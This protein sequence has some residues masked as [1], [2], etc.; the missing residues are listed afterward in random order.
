MAIILLQPDGVPITAKAERQGSAAL[1]GGGAGRPLGGRSGFRVDTASDVL[2]VTTTAWTVKPC[3]GMI[4]PGAQVDQG[5]YGWANTANITGT[6][7]P[8]DSTLPRK[9]I[10]Y[11]QINDSSSGDGSG[12]INADVKY[13]AGTPN[14][15]PSAPALPVRSFLIGTATVPQVGGGSPTVVLNTARFVAAGGIQPVYSQ[16]ERDGLNK[17]DGL[18]VRRND[19]ST[20]P[21]QVWTASANKWLS[22]NAPSEVYPCIWTGVS[23]WGTGGGLTGTYRVEGDRVFVHARATFGAAATLGNSVLKCPIPP[24]YPIAAGVFHLG[25]GEYVPAA[26]SIRPLTVFADGGQASVWV[27]SDP[28]RTPGDVPVSAAAG[29]YF[30]IEFSYLTSAV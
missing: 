21:V 16:G 27:A 18:T 19:L 24:G 2:T 26:G 15:S 22:T 11:I 1:Y 30:D 10:Y 6:P 4:D 8:P 23:D 9:D 20:R 5:M 14:A 13:L 29:S 17:Y 25:R 3:S 12:A 7:T 28:V